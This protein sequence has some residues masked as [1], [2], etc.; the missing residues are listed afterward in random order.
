MRMRKIGLII[1]CCLAAGC[2]FGDSGGFHAPLREQRLPSGKVVNVV[3]CVLAWGSEHDERLPGQ[4]A[5]ALEYLAT[6]PRVP[7]QEQE[8]EVLEVFELIRPISEQ[9]G[10][11]TATVAALRTADRTGTWDVFV[12]QRSASGRWSHTIQTIT[13]NAE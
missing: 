12:F 6:V 11:P 1:V 2:V 3:S 10:L 9:W 5:F 13:R 7:A 4:D 8:R